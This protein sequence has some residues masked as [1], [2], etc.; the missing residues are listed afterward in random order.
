MRSDQVLVPGDTAVDATCGHGHDMLHM[1][2]VL[3]SSGMLY[4]FDI[5]R[6]ATKSTKYALTESH[7]YLFKDN[8]G[9]SSTG[10]DVAL[11]NQCHSTMLECLGM[12]QPKLVCFNL[13]YLPHGR[14]EVITQM[15][16]TLEA[17]EGAL[18]MVCPGGLVSVI[19]Y[20]GHK[21][22]LEEYDAVRALGKQ[23]PPSDWVV[24]ESCVTN[25]RDAPILTLIWKMPSRIEASKV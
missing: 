11:F 7:K 6:E 4:G 12:I 14:K 24:L 3:G 25:R 19:S 21:G 2:D 23:L 20:V 13:G 8:Y 9:S 10:P 17:V 18:K 5:Q 1:V 15:D 22:G 16:T